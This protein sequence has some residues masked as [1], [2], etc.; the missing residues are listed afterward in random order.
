MADLPILPVSAR[1]WSLP[2]AGDGWRVVFAPVGADVS[3]GPGQSVVFLPTS[4]PTLLLERFAARLDGE[5]TVL[6]ARFRNDGED[7]AEVELAWR[8]FDG[9]RFAE[10]TDRM[11]IPPGAMR[12]V[13]HTVPA[14]SAV[15]VTM[16]TGSAPP[17]SAW[18]VRRPARRLG[19][20]QLGPPSRLLRRYVAADPLLREVDRLE[21]ADVAIARRVRPPDKVP[22]LVIAPPTAPPG[23]R[24]GPPRADVRFADAAA[25][26]DD[27]VLRDVEPAALAARR[28]RGFSAVG[29]DAL[30]VLLESAGEAVLVRTR[31]DVSPVPGGL[32][33][34]WLAWD[35]SDPNLA[36]TDAAVVLLANAVRWL[37]GVTDA[38]DA[39]RA[40]S[41]LRSAG[42]QGGSSLTAETSD[43]TPPHPGLYRDVAGRLYAVAE[44]AVQP[45][46]PAVDPAQ[47]VAHLPLPPP[48]RFGN[49]WPIGSALLVLAGLCWSVGWAL[50]VG[51]SHTI[52]TGQN[53]AAQV[54]SHHG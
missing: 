4:L 47:A 43:G 49:R 53:Q 6:L 48:R 45:G 33:Q 39:Y 54:R 2:P 21:E 29:N 30:A 42:W 19:V 27:P 18:R 16:R 35:L 24:K 28:V 51:L 25:A 41:P 44:P 31:P 26:V 7:P 23:F 10:E 46:T 36:P 34:V 20:I 38:E 14:A 5:E 17:Q 37:G 32:R 22:C 15:G 8:T 9:E 1:T 50:R 40:V 52:R 12:R 13:L 11:T 3:A